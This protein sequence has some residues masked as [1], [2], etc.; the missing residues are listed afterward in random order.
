M[1]YNKGLEIVDT[2]YKNTGKYLCYEKLY[3]EIKNYEFYKKSFKKS[4]QQILRVLD[5]NYKSYFKLLEM[6]NRGEYDRPI[7][8]P[9]S[10]YSKH[11]IIFQNGDNGYGNE[12]ITNIDGILK[13]TKILKI[14][15]N[16]NINGKI[17]QVVIKPIGNKYYE[18]F[19]FYDETSTVTHQ[20]DIKSNRCLSVDLGVNN[21]ST[22]YNNVGRDNFIIN[23][24]PIKA[25]NQF[26]NKTV[27]NVKMEL[28]LKNKKYS[29]NKL[30]RLHQKRDGFINNYMNQSVNKIIKF[31]I[32]NDINMLVVGY[33]KEW[34]NEINIGSVNN[35]KFVSIPHE[36]FKRKL[37]NKCIM[38]NI[39][40][41]ENEES[42]TSKCSSLDLEEVKKNET[43]VGK[44]IHRGLFKTK[45]G[46][47]I[48][49]DLNG[50]VNIMRKV[51]G[52]ELSNNSNSIERC[53]VH[54]IKFTTF[55]NNCR[56]DKIFNNLSQ[57][58]N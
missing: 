45:H 4:S 23:G 37:K 49:A 17:K 35:Q 41:I 27:K 26:Y 51:I 38:K 28:I 5:K 55:G 8:P 2:Y 12:N 58:C 30:C 15:F 16:Y 3:H 56:T 9:K 40:F 11:N 24:K 13:L 50:A 54:P 34:K 43:Y 25:Y 46:H 48:N 20:I 22:C 29:S 57:N 52:D 18:M 10:K 32:N 53:I 1:V 21:F 33:N 19:I 44:R 6:K 7:N 39:K 31:C 14:P 42:Y 36:K 47:E